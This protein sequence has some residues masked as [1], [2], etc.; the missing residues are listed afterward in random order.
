MSSDGSTRRRMPR[1]SLALWGSVAAILA[2]PLMAM[3]FTA[4]VAWTAG[5][6]AFAAA[7]LGGA[8]LAWEVARGRLRR[9]STRLVA[10]GVILAAV[11]AVWAQ[12]AVGIL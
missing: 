2:A 6:F 10:A 3:R 12:A 9:P 7:L 5:D 8:G 1:G 11:L 4:E